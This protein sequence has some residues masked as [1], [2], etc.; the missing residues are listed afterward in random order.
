ML[1]ELVV[2][3]YA[4]VE[5]V[6]VRFHAGLNLLT[7]ETGSGKSIIVDA[8]GLLYG[9]RAS[10]DLVRTGADRARIAGI[11]E[12]P[13]TPAF[14]ALAS[15]SGIE[16]EDGELLIEREI[17]SSGKS[18]AFAGS[19]PVTVALLREL[20][21]HWGDIHGQHD[22]QELFDAARQL[23]MLDAFG[24]IDTAAIALLHERWQTIR[25][26]IEA[27]DRSEQEK[28][29]LADLWSFQKRE[30]DDA[31]L[32]PGED[33]ALEADRRVLMNVAKLDEYARSA[34]D[35]LYDAEGAALA[36]VRQARK[37]LEDLC[38][39]DPALAETLE[40]LK[41]AEIA[42]DEASRSLQHYLA[43]L[44]GDPARLDAIETRLA[45]I[46]KLK[47]KYGTT[48]AEILAFLADVSEKLQAVASAG[49]HRAKLS[50]ELEEAA[51]AYEKAARK[52]SLA[53][54]K[55]AR[56]LEAAA[57][58]E[59]ASL[60][61]GGTR[62]QVELTEGEWSPHGWDRARFLLSA[63]KGEEPRPLEKVASGGELSRLALALKT[64]AAGNGEARSGV[65]RTLVFDEVDTGVG[66]R[67]AES[68]GRRLKRLAAGHQV[69]CV[70]HAPQIAGFADHHYVVAKG[71]AA[72]RTVASIEELPTQTARAREIGRML[73]GEKMTEEAIRQAEQLIKA[74]AR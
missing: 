52:A 54:G 24:G 20:A 56:Q 11:F 2:E 19:R 42:I 64:C 46:D 17:L 28:L 44:E 1:V 39:I 59:L 60:A 32:Q 5:H 37:R 33:D 8:L 70:T 51:A 4:V 9:G 25:R 23:D 65:P 30:I 69:L 67:T 18:R 58:D 22:Q 38:R 62:F 68:V 40:M 45:A 48:V 50:G 34:Y 49:E 55:A 31:R 12:A 73:S 21:P 57:H 16:I 53:R 15:E 26:D 72:G 41:P 61:M 14:Q 29:R 36:A 43:G 47:R 66:G 7:G 13:S 6:R 74:G 27:L 10:A 63:N 35:L 71:E 3:N